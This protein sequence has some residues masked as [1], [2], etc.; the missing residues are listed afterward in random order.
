MSAKAWVTSARATDNAASRWS[1]CSW[2]AASPVATSLLD[3]LEFHLRQFQRGLAFIEGGDLRLKQFDL[4][5][6]VLHGVLEFPALTSG[7]CFDAAHRCFS[8]RQ[9]RLCGIDSRFLDRRTMT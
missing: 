3:P 5:V 1:N 8:R 2:L 4:V 6:D 9:V 7:P